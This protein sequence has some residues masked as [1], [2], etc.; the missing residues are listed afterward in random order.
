MELEKDYEILRKKYALPMFEEL[1][2][3]FEIHCIEDGKFLIKDIR[4]KIIE[5]IDEF[6]IMVEDILQPDTKVSNLYE[7]R[8]FTEAD[9]EKIF[10]IFRK[11]MRIKRR[12]MQLMIL[13]NEKE[14][15]EFIKK[16]F[17]EWQELKEQLN[18]VVKKLIEAWETETD[19]KE[20]LSYLG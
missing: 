6:C 8:V 19:I 7:S 10:K 20:Q 14:D 5:K 1:D 17:S 3:E 12:A 4:Q 16:T 11:L 18:P 9:K 2:I 13:N 15:A